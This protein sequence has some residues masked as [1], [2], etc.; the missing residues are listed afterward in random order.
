M[1]ALI[2]ATAF[3]VAAEFAFVAVDRTT[4][5]QQAEEGNRGAAMVLRLL[6]QLSFQLS[7]A[8]LGITIAAVVLGGHLLYFLILLVTPWYLNTLTN[9][10]IPE[11]IWMHLI[12][13]AALLIGLRWSSVPRSAD[14][15][16]G[17]PS[18]AA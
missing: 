13:P 15:P 6:R 14:E 11:R 10:G 2:A 8:Q 16:A 5:E 7:G 1:A 12:G 17:S 4:I 9:T 3:F 18:A